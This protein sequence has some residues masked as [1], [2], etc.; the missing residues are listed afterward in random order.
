MWMCSH[1]NQILKLCVCVC[2]CV[3]SPKKSTPPQRMH[4]KEKEVR[5]RPSLID[6]PLPPTL[7]GGHHH[8]PPQS[9]NRQASLLPEMTL[10]KRPKSV[11]FTCT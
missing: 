3:F 1:H 5:S 10:K 4:R 8:S 6:L 7:P 9:P 2:V 11:P